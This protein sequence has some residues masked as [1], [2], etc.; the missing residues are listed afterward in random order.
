MK[1]PTNRTQHR[2]EEIVV[3][4]RQADEAL[5]KGVAIA[6]VGLSPRRGRSDLAPLASRGRGGEPMSAS[7]SVCFAARPRTA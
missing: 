1:G 5:A 6:E 4:L 3:K 7:P 2:P